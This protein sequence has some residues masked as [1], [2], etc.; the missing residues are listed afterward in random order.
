MPDPPVTLAN[1]LDRLTECRVVLA[2]GPSREVGDELARL[3]GWFADGLGDWEVVG[4]CR[5]GVRIGTSIP[6]Q[7]ELKEATRRVAQ[8]L[9]S[10]FAP[11]R[12]PRLGRSPRCWAGY[13]GGTLPRSSPRANDSRRRST[14]GPSVAPS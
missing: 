12:C 7:A 4:K 13:P 3:E 1:L 10:R 2:S 11:S 8:S 9:R 6:N 5:R 14:P